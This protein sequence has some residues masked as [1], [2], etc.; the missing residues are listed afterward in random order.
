MPDKHKIKLISA[1]VVLAACL[2]GAFSFYLL[3]KNRGAHNKAVI[4]HQITTK[5]FER[6]LLGNDYNLT[7]SERAKTQWFT[8]QEEL[9]NLANSNVGTFGSPKEKEFLA[10]I[11]STL[12]DSRGIFQELVSLNGNSPGISGGA[13]TE[14]KT[15]R[16]FGRRAAK[17]QE[18]ISAAE[19]LRDLNDQNTSDTV[20]QMVILFGI[21]GGLFAVV[22]LASLAEIW[23]TANLLQKQKAQSDAILR[24]IGDAVFAINTEQKIVLF[25]KTAAKITGFK[26]LEVLGRPYTEILQFVDEKNKV[27]DDG[28][29]RRALRGKKTHMYNGAEIRTKSGHY[30]PIADSAAPI[31]NSGGEVD[32]AVVV[33]RD[34]TPERELE[35][36]K[37]EF[38]SIASHQLRTP[39]G[40][41]Q[42]NTELLLTEAKELSDNSTERLHEMRSSTSRALNL[43]HDL[44]SLNKIQQGKIEHDPIPTDLAEVAV[45][46][47]REIK[48]LADKKDVTMQ[49]DIQK[50]LKPVVVD[51]KRIREVIQNLVSNAV[52]YTPTNGRVIVT[53]DATAKQAIVSVADTGIGIPME[54]QRRIFSK[55]FRAR[56]ASEISIEGTGLGL[57]IARAYAKEWG[58]RIW[59]KSNSGKGTTFYLSVPRKAKKLQATIKK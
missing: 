34:V 54:D 15:T 46:A 4:A 36:S 47:V 12:A 26:E 49:L 48:P 59:F 40:S 53:I 3:Q 41:L 20:Q 17:S 39:L 25:N 32:G 21:T 24:D 45:L 30:V 16:L 31:F 27:P 23:R 52:K 50:T 38:F 22:L 57:F 11:Q 18:T 5:I 42:W 28:F 6:N 56:N 33:F 43:I 37:D 8:K 19:G 13:V 51:P 2:F 10:R 14:E 58:G 9:E 29:I 44:L 1:F 35:R 55:Y 7:R